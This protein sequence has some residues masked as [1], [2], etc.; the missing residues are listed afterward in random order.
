[1][2]VVVST[3]ISKQYCASIAVASILLIVI[4]PGTAVS[5]YVMTS[6]FGLLMT[7][8]KTS[9]DRYIIA[10]IAI[11]AYLYFI[12]DITADKHLRKN[13]NVT[14]NITNTTA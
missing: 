11:V 13:F 2:A 12:S 5:F 9:V 8:L 3:M 7:R 1:M 6:L 4:M 10:V 14:S